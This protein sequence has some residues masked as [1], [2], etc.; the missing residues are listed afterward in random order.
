MEILGANG[1]VLK[2]ISNSRQ[3]EGW[4]PVELSGNGNA[5]GNGVYFVR[6]SVNGAFQCV[7]RILVM[8]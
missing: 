1:K 6:F 4:H 7:K 2:S 8:Q 3:A 5:N